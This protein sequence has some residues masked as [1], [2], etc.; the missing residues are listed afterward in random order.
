M[1]QTERYIDIISQDQFN[2]KNDVIDIVNKISSLEKQKK[3]LMKE[4][5]E[6]GKI[7]VHL[8]QKEEENE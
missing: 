3:Q 4:V 7:M 5:D 8:K 1:N 2:K 6:L